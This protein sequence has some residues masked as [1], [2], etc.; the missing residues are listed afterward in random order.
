MDPTCTHVYAQRNT[1]A[2]S[3]SEYS[4]IPLSVYIKGLNNNNKYVV[5]V[6]FTTIEYNK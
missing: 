1:E 6:A 4:L 3:A 2:L 5:C